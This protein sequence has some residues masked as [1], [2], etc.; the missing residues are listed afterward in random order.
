MEGGARPQ[1]E[2]TVLER[3]RAGMFPSRPVYTFHVA[4][5][6]FPLLLVSGTTLN[7]KIG[8]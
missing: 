3:V 5:F 8:R 4:P 7:N 2:S 6:S 1:A